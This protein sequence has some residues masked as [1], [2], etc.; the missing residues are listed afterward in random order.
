MDQINVYL[1]RYKILVETKKELVLDG[2]STYEFD[3]D[4]K[5]VSKKLEELTEQLPLSAKE[6]ASDGQTNLFDEASRPASVVVK[7][8]LES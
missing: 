6:T 1:T 3:D 5:K 7:P 2:R 8:Y 4:L